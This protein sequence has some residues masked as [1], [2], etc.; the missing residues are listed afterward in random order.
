[1][2]YTNRFNLPSPIV[3][4]IVRD[5]YSKGASDMSV[6]EIIDSPRIKA[7]QTE[8]GHEVV[9]DVSDKIFSL[10]GRGVHQILEWG[11]EEHQTAEERIFLPVDIDGV[12]VMVS[13]AMDLQDPEGDGSVIIRDWKVTTVYAFQSD[14]PAWV[15][16]L[17]CYAHMV[18]KVKGVEVQGLQI[19]AILRDFSKSKSNRDSEYPEAAIQTLDLPLWPPEV[20]EAYFL[21]RV[22]MHVDARDR[23]MAG[24]ELPLCTDEER[25]VDDPQ[26]AVLKK[27]NKRASAVFPTESEAKLYISEQKKPEEFSIEHRQSIPKRCA[28]W[29]SVS[30]WC[31]Q[32]RAENPEAT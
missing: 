27:G 4:A 19:G 16:Q 32:F 24:L 20:A 7:L 8:Y 2:Q 26:W 14:K 10:L 17:N 31:S 9:E 21:E 15:N 29:C 5:N 28:D 25:W 13:G 22:K 1:M 12:R 11:A 23:A 3:R 18:R 30:R 6:S